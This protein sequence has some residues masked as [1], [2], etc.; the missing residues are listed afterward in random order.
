MNMIKRFFKK[1]YSWFTPAKKYAT[2]PQGQEYENW[3]GV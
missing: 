3:L 2:I 1:T